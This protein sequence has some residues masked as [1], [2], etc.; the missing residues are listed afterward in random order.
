[1]VDKTEEVVMAIAALWGMERDA[2]GWGSL[3]ILKTAYAGR[4]YSRDR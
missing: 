2:L 4:R 1:M 3:Q